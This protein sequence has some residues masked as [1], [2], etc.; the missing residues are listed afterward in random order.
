M[1]EVGGGRGG[2]RSLL[3]L[4]LIWAALGSLSPFSPSH[5][6]LG[7]AWQPIIDP[8]EHSTPAQAH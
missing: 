7:L 6:N 3:A 4:L 5:T 2:Y 1:F 8:G